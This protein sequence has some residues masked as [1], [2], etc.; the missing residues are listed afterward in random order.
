MEMALYVFVVEN[1]KASHSTV[2]QVPEVIC[3]KGV[4]LEH[5]S[6]IYDNALKCVHVGTPNAHFS[7]YSNIP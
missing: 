1:E 7:C 4:N 2:G 6:L 3:S 5:A